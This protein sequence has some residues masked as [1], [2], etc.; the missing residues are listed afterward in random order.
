MAPLKPSFG[1]STA[2]LVAPTNSPVAPARRKLP[3]CMGC[4]KRIAPT[5]MG[6]AGEVGGKLKRRK[7][8]DGEAASA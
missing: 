1:A 3:I 7:L 2:R 4:K 8:G 6:D 5:A